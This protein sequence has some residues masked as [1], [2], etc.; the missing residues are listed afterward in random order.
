MSQAQKASAL[1]ES[2]KVFIA[3]VANVN[4]LKRAQLDFDDGSTVLI[5]RQLDGSLVFRPLSEDEIHVLDTRAIFQ[6]VQ[7]ANQ[8]EM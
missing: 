5:Q 1:L 8:F 4:K 6:P 7:L 3:P 2:K